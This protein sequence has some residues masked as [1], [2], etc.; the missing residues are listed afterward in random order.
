M[1]RKVVS[2]A[3]VAD[4]THSVAFYRDVLGLQVDDVSA[5]QAL[6]E[7]DGWPLLLAGPHAITPD[8][9]QTVLSHGATI[10]RFSPDLDNLAQRIRE[11]GFVPTVQATSWGDRTLT[12]TDPDGYQVSFWTTTSRTTQQTIDLYA[13]GPDVLVAALAGLAE[14]DITWKPA[15]DVWSIRE[16]VHHVVDMDTQALFSIKMAL[17]ESGRVVLGNPFQPE[18]WAHSLDYAQRDIAPALLLLRATRAHVLEL[19]EHL[20]DVMQ[21][22]ISNADGEQTAV[23]TFISMLASHL[24]LHVDEIQNVRDRYEKA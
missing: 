5:G 17:A 1:A 12:V 6:V 13:A 22:T 2:I 20:P 24:M 15:T 11:H 19:V 8:D 10:D 23:E 7:P 3:P 4:V 9:G 16:I 18:S 14:Q 21:R